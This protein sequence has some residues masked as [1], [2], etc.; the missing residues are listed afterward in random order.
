MFDIWIA[1]GNFVLEA[2]SFKKFFFNVYR[3]TNVSV[4]VLT[5]LYFWLIIVEL[6]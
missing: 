1:V 2:L 4:R 6:K 3:V 5:F